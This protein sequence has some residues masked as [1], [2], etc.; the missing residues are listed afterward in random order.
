M[1]IRVFM[2]ACI[3]VCVCIQIRK[4]MHT[5]LC[6]LYP[7]CG[8]YFIY[9]FIYSLYLCVLYPQC[10]TLDMYASIHVYVCIHTRSTTRWH[11]RSVCTRKC[12]CDMHASIHVY[13]CAY[14]YVVVL[15]STCDLYAHTHTNCMHEYT[16][17]RHIPYA[18]TRTQQYLVAHLIRAGVPAFITRAACVHHIGMREVRAPEAAHGRAV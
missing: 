1:H 10:G 4:C 18:C 2:Q 16:Q 6:V 5:Y 13:I 12:V 14:L 15:G 8:I 3:Y 11:M 7:Q 17:P 9:L